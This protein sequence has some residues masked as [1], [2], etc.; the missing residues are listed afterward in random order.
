MGTPQPEPHAC[1]GHCEGRHHVDAVRAPRGFLAR[2]QFDLIAH[3]AD[4]Y[5][6][7]GW[8]VIAVEPAEW[9]PPVPD[10]DAV[11]VV[12]VALEIP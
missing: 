11:A 4:A 2:D 3:Y 1:R 5:W 7:R 10:A 9:L 8:R 6:A 12:F